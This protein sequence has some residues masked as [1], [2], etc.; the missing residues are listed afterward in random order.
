MH[1]YFEQI[2]SMSKKNIINLIGCVFITAAMTLTSSCVSNKKIAYF[3]DIQTINQAQLE[4]AS[5]FVEPTIQPDDILSINVFT[6][7]PQTGIVVNQAASTPTL[8]GNTNNSIATPVSY[9]HLTLPTICS[10]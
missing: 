7:N 1:F 5:K 4:N 6:L 8:G 2:I 3:Q 10:V 9:T